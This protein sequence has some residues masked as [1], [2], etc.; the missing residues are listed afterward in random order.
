MRC[1]S[2]SATVCVM[3]SATRR[4]RKAPANRPHSP[5]V[6]SAA[7]RSTTPPFDVRA[8][9]SKAPTSLRP[10]EVP[11]SSSSWLH[12]VGIGERLLFAQ[13]RCS[14]TTFAESEPRCSSRL[15]ENQAKRPPLV[16]VLWHAGSEQEEAI[17]L[18]A[19]REGFRTL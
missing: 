8:P 13:S 10:P 16:G 12:S 2:R 19:L 6:R 4:S 9:P 7:P 14:T 18:G 17:Y 1:R 3:A 15:G 11:K 5:I